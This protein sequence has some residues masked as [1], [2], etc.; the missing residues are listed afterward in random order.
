M[1]NANE[2][3]EDEKR[4]ARNNGAIVGIFVGLLI[5]FLICWLT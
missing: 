1:K 5:G 2:I 3:F 4:K